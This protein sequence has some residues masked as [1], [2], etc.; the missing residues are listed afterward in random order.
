MDISGL[1]GFGANWVQACDKI[2][3]GKKK[4]ILKVHFND[5]IR[6]VRVSNEEVATLSLLKQV[7]ARLLQFDDVDDIMVRYKD[8]D[9]DTISLSSDRELD[10]FLRRTPAINNRASFPFSSSSSS[11]SSRLSSDFVFVGDAEQSAQ[12]F[13]NSSELCENDNDASDNI[14]PSASSSLS[15]RQ[16]FRLFVES[17][18]N[19]LN[20][21]TEAMTSAACI[22]D[23]SAC[24]FDAILRLAERMIRTP[25]SPVRPGFKERA[26]SEQELKSMLDTLAESPI[27]R[28]HVLPQVYAA[29]CKSLNVEPDGALVLSVAAVATAEP[30]H[31]GAD[32][33]AAAVAES[34][35]SSP[36]SPVSVERDVTAARV[37]VADLGAVWVHDAESSSDNAV[38]VH[39]SQ[40]S[41]AW[42]FR[43]RNTG[44]AS[45][46]S[47]ATLQWVGGDDLA[48]RKRI[49]VPAVKCTSATDV[50][51][52]VQVPP[53]L[54]AIVVHM[55]LTTPSGQH[56]G[57]RCSVRARIIDR[58]ELS[59]T[60]PD[61]SVAA[62]E[63]TPMPTPSSVPVPSPSS[64]PSPQALAAQS[65]AHNRM[66]RLLSRLKE[67][68]FAENPELLRALLERHNFD[69]STVIQVLLS[70][71]SSSLTH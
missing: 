61:Q 71:P 27:L 30:D 44:R 64:V 3:R 10:L 47:G 58:H 9:D 14:A 68:G 18:S 65:A 19:S 52:H 53:R 31:G 16:V 21:P 28:Q 2:E 56:F 33:V 60:K 69:I 4:M 59:S 5:E 24:S 57:E 26:L 22:N 55:Q 40:D 51:V 67:M 48:T 54:G 20:R 25:V 63:S 7:L 43:L 13:V 34:S 29:L 70:S 36:Y 45:W 32:D 41:F 66:N 15:S 6:R 8:E 17:K 46:P 1:S 11:S 37:N 38:N 62:G 50:Y 12:L 35:S 42:C 49:P 23:V 39:I